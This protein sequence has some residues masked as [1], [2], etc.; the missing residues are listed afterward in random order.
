MFALSYFKPVQHQVMRVR[1]S[2]SWRLQS[3]NAARWA[4]Y[5]GAQIFESLLD[6][7][8]PEKTG[9][10]NRWIQKF[11]RE[12][13]LTPNRA[14]TNDEIQSRLSGTLEIGFLKLRLKGNFHVLQLLRTCAPAFLQI[15]LSD[16]TLWPSGG[17]FTAVSIAHIFASARY[18]LGL[19][20]LLDAFCA[21]AYAL[22]PTLDYDTSYPP[23]GID[24]HP[25]EWINGYRAEDSIVATLLQ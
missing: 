25:T 6:G 19:F 21:M 9:A 24:S 4:M 14:L 5:I 22:P 23:F 7:V 10:Y 17:H 2:V 12:L 16:P 13:H 11:E 8:L 18:E 20:I 15:A 3:S 1:E